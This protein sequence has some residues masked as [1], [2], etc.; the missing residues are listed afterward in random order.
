MLMKAL[1][2]STYHG[3]GLIKH[4]PLSRPEVLPLVLFYLA[5]I[6]CMMSSVTNKWSCRGDATVPWGHSF[7]REFTT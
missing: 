5:A 2:H 6:V 7:T 3:L 4:Q 1:G